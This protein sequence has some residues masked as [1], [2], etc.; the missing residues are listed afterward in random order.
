VNS[1]SVLANNRI[2]NPTVVNTN[3]IR[4]NGETY[5]GR[6]IRINNIIAVKNTSGV[7]V[8]QWTVSGSGTNYRIFDGTGDSCDI[9]IYAS[10]NIANSTIPAYPFSVI[11]LNSQFDSS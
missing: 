7:L 3:A 9:R 4:V 10:T 8:T 5:E 11:A 2:I 1:F 6:L